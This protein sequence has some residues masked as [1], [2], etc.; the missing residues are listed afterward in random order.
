MTYKIAWTILGLFREHL[1][2]DTRMLKGVVEMDYAFFGGRGYGG[3][4]NK[5]LSKVMAMKVK[6]ITTE[7]R[8]STVCAEIAQN[9]SGDAAWAFVVRTRAYLNRLSL[10]T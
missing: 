9:I 1:K 2:Q 8:G 10:L 5:N 4:Y 3:T 6:V 7:E